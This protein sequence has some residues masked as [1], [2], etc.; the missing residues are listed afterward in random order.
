M[1]G[2]CDSGNDLA[3]ELQGLVRQI[4]WWRPDMHSDEIRNHIV[5]RALATRSD[6]K[7]VAQAYLV[8]AKNGI[9]M[10]WETK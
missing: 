3:E 2:E 7:A 1:T 5:E 8:R 6:P 10:P 4:A 9:A